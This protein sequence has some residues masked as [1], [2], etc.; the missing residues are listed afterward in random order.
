M[1]EIK[2]TQ[3]KVALVDDEDFEY[4]NQWKWCA[5]KNCRTFYAIRTGY[6]PCKKTIRMH[7][8]ILNSPLG[9]LTDHI[10]HNGLN[11]QKSNLRICTAA[12]NGYNKLP[13]GKYKGV[14]YNESDGKMH[15]R[16]QIMHNYKTYFLGYFNTEE[17]AARVY[18]VKAKELFGEFANLN[19]K[20]SENT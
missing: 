14:Y 17:E 7:R 1:K 19:F 6:D 11:N 18:D 16:A 9:I 15:I 10:D 3:G 4:L 2:L 12:Q 20:D 8:I 5:I 13:I